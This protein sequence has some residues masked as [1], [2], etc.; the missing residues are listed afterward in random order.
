MT[1]FIRGTIVLIIVSILGLSKGVYAQGLK[2]QHNNLSTYTFFDLWNP[3]LFILILLVFGIYLYGMRSREAT[4]SVNNLRKVSFLVGLIILFIALG[5]PLHILGDK[6]LFSAHMLEQSLIYIVMPPLILLGLSEKMV[7]PTVEFCKK[8]KILLIIR[9][10]LVSLLLFNTL[11]SFYHMPMIFD[12]LVSNAI[13]HNISHILLTITAF[14]MWIPIIPP[15]KSLDSLSAIKKIAYIFGAGILLTPAC[16]L[17]IFAHSPMY[18]TYAIAPQLFEWLPPLTDQQLGGIIM[19]IVQEIIY[20]F[21]IG[22]VFFKWA[23]EERLKDKISDKNEE[24]MKVL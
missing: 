12:A 11:L 24:V 3:T 13:F 7:A 10:P 23:K 21:I 14:L 17:I 5:S 9:N 19:K 20:G 2:E 15:A 4:Y 16:A 22:H 1:N 8:F 18:T 6:Y